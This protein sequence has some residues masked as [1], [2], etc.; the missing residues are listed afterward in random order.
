[1]MEV[2]IMYLKTLQEG[3]GSVV[4]TNN[5]I[6]L[7][8]NHFKTI[9][10][11]VLITSSDY[12]D[13]FHIYEPNIKDQNHVFLDFNVVDGKLVYYLG[14]NWSES[15]QFESHSAWEEHLNKMAIKIDNPIKIKY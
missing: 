11:N 6:L 10:S 4:E 3:N 15:K 2:N 7:K 13:G 12:Y 1:M 5:G 14:F 9:L 8:Q